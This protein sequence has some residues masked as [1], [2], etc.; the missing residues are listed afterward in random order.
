MIQVHLKVKLHQVNWIPDEHF[1]S[2]STL[3]E[4][5]NIVILKQFC[6]SDTT[7]ESDY[8]Y[9]YYYILLF[10][11]TFIRIFTITQQE[12]TMYLGYIMLQLICGYNVWYMLYYFP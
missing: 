5:C 1:V 10:C 2:Q 9:D 4:N 8:Y 6:Q 7:I 12:Q 11:I 3:D